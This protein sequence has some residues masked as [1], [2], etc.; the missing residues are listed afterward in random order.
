MKLYETLEQQLK[1]NQNYVTDEGDL[2]KWVVLNKAQSFDEELIGLLLENTELKEKFFVNVN[3]VMV[4]NQNLFVQF[5]EQKN[6]LN[7]SYTRYK[8]KVGLTINGKLLKQNNDVA[9]VWP[10]KDCVLEGG[11]TREEDTREEIFFNEILAQDEITQL[12]EPKVLTNA[13][14]FDK[15]GE[16]PFNAFT[17]D[18]E[19]NKQRGLA[20]D[21]I[22]DNLIIK[23]NNLLALHT[24]EK[25]F[26]GKVK[27][28]YIDP[29]YNTGNDSF[30]YNDSFNQSTW[31]TFMKNRLD[32]A[33]RLLSE[34]GS[35]AISIDQNEIGRSLILMDEV[36]GTVNKKNIITTKRSSVSG[37]KVINPGVVNISEYVILYAKNSTKWKPNKTFREKHWDKRYN[38]F[39]LNRDENASDW[40]YITVLEAFA[41]SIGVKKS[42]LKNNFKEDFEIKLKEFVLKNSD[43]VIQFAYLDNKS[44]SD[45]ARKLKVISKNDP[46]KTYVLERD[47]KSNYYIYRGKVLLFMESR[48]IEVEG[49]KAFGELISD[50]WDDVLPNDI[51]NEGGVTLR[52]GK[53]P[54]KLLNRLIELCSDDND[55][56]MDYHLGS[57]TTAAVAHK[58]N[59][60]YIGIEQLDYGE[61]DCVKRLKNVINGE[62][63][64]VSKMTNW[65]GGGS[66]IYL[67]LKKY[68][69]TF[70]EQ[71]EEAQDTE[72]LLHIWEQM[73]AKSFLNYNL[74]IK[75]QDEHIEE[76]KAFT[77]KEQK[78]HLCEILDKN[79]LYVN[80]SSLNDTDFA[81]SEEE[82]KVTKDFYQIND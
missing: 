61:H 32:V 28:I 77:L 43:K 27:L 49:E 3:D 44:V 81:C 39:I 9:L 46:S 80:L 11:Q 65:P 59:R 47:D 29:P 12:L 53:K 69:Q 67:E 71:I 50:I 33:K 45:A 21:T 57:G 75:K 34:D 2:K 20:E 79:Q 31:L 56:I 42:K 63:S 25:E 40:K 5:F 72:A 22:T 14:V 41:N 38:N 78:Q 1:K 24:L 16:H 54:E 52:K 74:D 36:F 15:D 13:K 64:G 55:I 58:M 70:I 8:N 17:R 62:Q 37:A 10:F 19:L 68:N 51:H 26:A 48:L 35:I 4:F 30:L 23:G 6:Y 73:K 82:K 18:A 66:F 7:D 76:F 60:Q